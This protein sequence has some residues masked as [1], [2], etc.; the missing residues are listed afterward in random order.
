MP[1]RGFTLVELLVVIAIIGILIV[2][3]LPA[4]Q[5]AR[6]AS[7]RISCQNNLKQLALATQNYESV[8]HCL[9]AAGT[10]GNAEKAVYYSY[11]YWRV[12]L[13]SGTNQSWVVSLL[14]YFEEQS[15][16]DQ[17]DIKV[18]VTQQPDNPQE[19]QPALLLCP[20]D[21]A[22]NSFYETTD[23]E[24]GA[25]VR[26]GKANYAAFVSPYHVDSLYPTGAISLFGHELHEITDGTSTTLLLAEVRT[27]EELRDQ[28]GAW[29]LPWS[30]ASLLA[31]DMHPASVKQ[32]R[33]NPKA[34]Y[35]P[36]AFSLG[37]TQPPNSAQPD[38]LYDCPNAAAAQ[39]ERMPCNAK[40]WGYISA[41]PRG[42]HVGGV[43]VVFLD[44]H[45]AFLPDDVDEYAMCYMIDI[46]DAQ[47]VE[48]RY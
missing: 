39:F 6:E 9:P 11:S 45:V 12:D 30:G 4:V 17:F 32:D 14:P 1:R 31:F 43:N 5:A 23:A 29:A 37:L 36:A 41:A 18:R 25:V 22:R 42:L 48:E 19:A 35:S 28:R 27:R 10:F 46:A 15:L 26:F 47:N 13:K 8:N 33:G 44:G 3:L 7:R 2:L 24:T 16:H 34:D 20:S 40:G 38:V 21:I